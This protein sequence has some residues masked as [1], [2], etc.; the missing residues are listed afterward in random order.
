MTATDDLRE[1]ARN[2]AIKLEKVRSDNRLYT[3]RDE[4]IV[5]IIVETFEGLLTEQPALVG[6]LVEALEEIGRVH[7]PQDF[8]FHSKNTMFKIAREALTKY[9]AARGGK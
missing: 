7:G 9:R 3:F 6:E 2:L 8:I 5:S 4:Y 1:K